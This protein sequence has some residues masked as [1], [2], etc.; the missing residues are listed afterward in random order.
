[1]YTKTWEYEDIFVH[2]VPAVILLK[3]DILHSIW[4]AWY[5]RMAAIVIALSMKLRIIKKISD[6]EISFETLDLK[7]DFISCYSFCRDAYSKDFTVSHCRCLE[8]GDCALQM[9]EKFEALEKS[10][11]IV[12]HIESLTIYV[13]KDRSTLINFKNK[14]S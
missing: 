13:Q 2:P 11:V 9:L 12:H 4:A 8:I 14:D 3:E 1:M 7:S 5:E 6:S 10:G